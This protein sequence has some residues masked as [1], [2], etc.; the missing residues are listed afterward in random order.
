[1]NAELPYFARFLL[2]FEYPEGCAKNA[3]SRYYVNAYHHPTVIA[4]C[5]NQSLT[6][7]VFIALER[8]VAFLNKN[9]KICQA[10]DGFYVLNSVGMYEILKE[11]SP[12]I[13]SSISVKQFSTAL[14]LVAKTCNKVKSELD[15]RGIRVWH[16][17]TDFNEADLNNELVED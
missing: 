10:Q 6:S 13:C 16:I 3:R 11:V 2:S 12:V 1:L 5:R 7:M 17:S 8:L 9:P 14:G 15:R 4:I